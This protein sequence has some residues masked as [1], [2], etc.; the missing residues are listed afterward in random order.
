MAMITDN[1]VFQVVGAFETPDI[2]L[3]RALLQESSAMGGDL[4]ELGVYYGRSAV[5]MGQYVQP[6]EEFTC[7]DLFES[8]A[9]EQANADENAVYYP[10]LTREG[11]EANYR[12]L[13]GVL[14]RVVTGFSQDIGQHANE[15]THRFVHIDASHLYD[16]VKADLDAVKPLMREGGIVALDD[17]RAEHT[18][19]VAAAAWQEVTRTGLRPFALSPAKMYAT[20]GDPAP[21]FTF[22]T[23]WAHSSGKVCLVESIN[24]LDV[25][26]VRDQP[27]IPDPPP[28]PLRPWVPPVIWRH[29]RKLRRFKPR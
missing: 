11:F 27:P 16:N 24:G 8:G 10:G 1:E 25:A 13:H 18:P 4:A 28:H 3:F 20:W 26:L 12:R 5:L 17:F 2:E 9:A 14:P 19:G 15:G 6:G 21:W 22:V 29:V 7:I 23:T